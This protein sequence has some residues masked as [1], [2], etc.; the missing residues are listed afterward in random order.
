MTTGCFARDCDRAAASRWPL[1]A[2]GAR[3]LRV[4]FQ[5]AMKISQAQ[6]ALNRPPG[7]LCD[8]DNHIP[9]LYTV[10]FRYRVP[11]KGAFSAPPILSFPTKFGTFGVFLEL[12]TIFLNKQRQTAPCTTTSCMSQMFTVKASQLISKDLQCFGLNPCLPLSFRVLLRVKE[13]GRCANF[14]RNVFTS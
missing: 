14:K 3:S 12:A 5:K 10:L 7:K 6:N 13:M 2:A 4:I 8:D 9:V 1:K 11:L